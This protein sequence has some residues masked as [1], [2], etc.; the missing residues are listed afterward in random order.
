VFGDSKVKD[1]VL[2]PQEGTI[3]GEKDGLEVCSSRA[4]H[5]PSWHKEFIFEMAIE[6]W[7]L[8]RYLE[9]L[10]FQTE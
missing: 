7:N 8:A 2:H 1:M 5:A 6:R 4:L 3:L 9:E 10:E